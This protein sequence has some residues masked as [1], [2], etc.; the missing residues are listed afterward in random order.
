MCAPIIAILLIDNEL[1]RYIKPAREL[2]TVQ[3]A[4]ELH[5][6]ITAPPLEETMSRV[7]PQARIGL[8][9][10]AF[11]TSILTACSDSP[12]GA[13]QRQL[14]TKGPLRT[15][16][17]GTPQTTTVCKVGPAGNY[18]FVLSSDP[19]VIKTDGWNGKILVSNPFTVAAG[20]CLDVYQGADAADGLYV[21]EI[22]LPSGITL[23]HIVLQ[24]KGGDC[25][26][27]LA[28]CAQT[29]TGVPYVHFE[30][31]TTKAYTVTFYNVG[32]PP[33]P[34]PPSGQGCTPGYWKNH[35][36]AWAKTPYKTTQYFNKVFGVSGNA[37]AF[38]PDITLLAALDNG[39]GDLS[40][41]GRAG[42]AALLNASYGL[43]YGMTPAQVITAV[44]SAI[45]SG[46]FEATKTL[47][48]DMNNRGCPLN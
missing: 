39:G 23:D 46:N 31:F 1:R 20:Q 34:P 9:A 26:T 11:A 47:L 3:F 48:D 5:S 27:D 16:L 15:V 40:A 44:K 12:T 7:S 36:D 42:T 17:P 21:Q 6:L 18:T 22:N 2:P 37:N 24:L 19:T 41:L 25:A 43:N 32:N 33:P 4:P 38:S 30:V 45:V 14:G 8:I 35:L 10:V 29:V 28:F 13:P